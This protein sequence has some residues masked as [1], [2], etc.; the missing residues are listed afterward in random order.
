M[1]SGVLPAPKHSYAAAAPASNVPSSSSTSSSSSSSSPSS[2]HSHAGLPKYPHRASSG[3]RPTQPSDF[4]DGGAY[5][6]IHLVQ[7][8]L[9][10]GK[11]G[12]KSMAVVAVDVNSQGQVTYDAIVKQGSNRNKIVQTSLADCKEANSALLDKE[13]LALPRRDEEAATAEKTR[14]ALQLLMEGK[15]KKGVTVGGGALAAVTAK[16]SA[17]ELEPTYIRYTPNPDA[18]GYNVAAKERVIRMVEAQVDPMEPPKHKNTKTPRGPG[19]PPA[20]ILHSPPRKL[21]VEDQQAWKIPPCISNWKNA[22]GYIIPLDKRLAADGRG[23]Q[24]VTINNKFAA[25]SEALYVSERTAAEDLR[26]RNQIRKKMAMREKEDKEAD[27][28]EL[29]MRAR[30]G[31]AGLPVDD[32]GGA[33][34]G[35]YYAP[36]APGG[37]MGTGSGA[38]D[39]EELDEERPRVD[40]ATGFGLKARDG[41]DEYE[42]D[43]GAWRDGGVGAQGESEEDRVAR[44][45][46]EAL[47]LQRRKERERELRQENLKVGYG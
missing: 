28:R 45:Q 6:E 43:E 11:P 23:L 32:G 16:M 33:G 29:A 3:F 44:Q 21:T 36:S 38:R 13:A 46:R 47:R 34:G 2:S 7:Y 26:V 12:A 39:R 27:L 41:E 35:G 4:G 8:P 40:V 31:R 5:P 10:M 42:D 9:G 19:S 1:L 22:Q 18:P 17:E 25:L 37:S 20:P 14:Q 30:L 15:L 24:E